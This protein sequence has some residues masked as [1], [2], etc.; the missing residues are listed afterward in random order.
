MNADA[1]S[2]TLPPDGRL[3]VVSDIHGQ[4]A[5]LKGLLDKINFT[6]RDRLLIV[7]DLTER[8]ESCLKTLRFIMALCREGR[9]AV[10][11]GNVE[12]K[13]LDMLDNTA[14]DADHALAELSRSMKRYWGHST[15]DDMARELGFPLDTDS[16][17][18]IALFRAHF[19]EEI[20]FI[21][22]LPTM[23][24]AGDY[25]FVHGGVPTDNVPSLVGQDAHGFLKNDDFLG[26]AARYRR[27]V[28]VGHW[29]VVNYNPRRPDYAPLIDRKRRVI[30]LD[31]GCGI[32]RYGQLNALILR[33]GQPGFET[34]AWDPFEIRTALD[35]QPEFDEGLHVRFGHNELR[36][37]NTDADTARVEWIE[38]K[39]TLTVP[40]SFIYREHGKPFLSEYTTYRPAVSPGDRL[41]VLGTFGCLTLVKKD[42]IVG[43]YAGRLDAPSPAAVKTNVNRKSED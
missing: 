36:L 34:A 17:G 37:L 7:G 11:M 19:A 14:P 8:G 28:V 13:Q 29:P 35:P 3:I 30:S 10:S 43:W 38:G 12:T 32:K 16:D 20:A 31:G 25:L 18:V 40:A 2:M 24:D 22:S 4:L 6:P 15:F 1:T 21:R 27:W 39:T 41:S 33:A 26:H 42:S 5:Y 23:I 9:C